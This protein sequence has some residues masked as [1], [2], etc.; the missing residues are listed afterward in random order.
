MG[1]TIG[2]LNFFAVSYFLIR[3]KS[4]TALHIHTS[5]HFPQS[6][7]HPTP[8]W[9]TSVPW[10]GH[11]SER[12]QNLTKA[13]ASKQLTVTVSPGR[14]LEQAGQRKDAQAA[15]G[16]EE[17][18]LRHPDLNHRNPPCHPFCLILAMLPAPLYHPV[19]ISLLSFVPGLSLPSVPVEEQ[20]SASG[21]DSWNFF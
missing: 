19:P 8:A 4:N 20:I 11:C 16:A 2:Y 18:L 13:S 6:T 5:K 15:L 17:A 10:A 3:K 12:S 1:Y 14:K 7:Q 21:G 9:R